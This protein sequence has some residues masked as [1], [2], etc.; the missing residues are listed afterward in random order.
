MEIN[1]LTQKIIGESIYVHKELGPGLL[2]SAYQKCLFHRLNSIGLSIEIEKPLPVYFD[3]I[4]LDCG[5]RLDLVVEKTVVIEIK[6]IKKLKE[7]HLAQMLTYLKLGKYPL[8][9]LINFNEKRLVNGL[10]RVIL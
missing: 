8:G 7:I 6:S 4:F 10:K 9:L 2:E 5:Y 1:S 3:G